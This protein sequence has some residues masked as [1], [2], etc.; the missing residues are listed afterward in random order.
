MERSLPK[1]M[2][3]LNE[4]DFLSFKGFHTIE[5]Q[6]LPNFFAMLMGM[7]KTQVR[8]S[9]APNWYHPYDECPMIWKEFSAS[10]RYITAF[11]ED[12]IGS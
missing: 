6:T 2:Q 7:T 5:A 1:T 11:M 9:C 3:I 12:G 4:M 10:H 8:G